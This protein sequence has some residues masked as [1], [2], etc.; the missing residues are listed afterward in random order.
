MTSDKP[1]KGHKM[2]PNELGS[3]GHKIMTLANKNRKKWEKEHPNSNKK[4]QT[5]VGEASK[6][7]KNK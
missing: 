4:W 5:F 7:L 6:Q 1:K 2:T 3:V